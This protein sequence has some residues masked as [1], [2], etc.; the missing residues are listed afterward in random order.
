M[1]ARASTVDLRDVHGDCRRGWKSSV[2]MAALS[3]RSLDRRSGPECATRTG[4]G[5]PAWL[6]GRSVDDAPAQGTAVSGRPLLLFAAMSVIWG[7]P[8]LFIR[9]AV[10]EVEPAFLVF[11]R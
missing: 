6:L 3:G 11:A 1:P 4:P 9:I 2:G 8:Y 10:V 7:I 5:A